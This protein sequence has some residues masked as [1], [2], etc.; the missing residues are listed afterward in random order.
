MNA[1]VGKY[2]MYGLFQ[3]VDQVIQKVGLSDKGEKEERDQ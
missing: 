1:C 3:M 2:R